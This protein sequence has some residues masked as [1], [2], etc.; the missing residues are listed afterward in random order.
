[1]KHFNYY[2]AA[3]LIAGTAALA[4]CTS[5]EITE[6]EQPA[7]HVYTMAISASLGE[8]S[9][10]TRALTESGTSLTASWEKETDNVYVKK[11][12][13]WLGGSLQPDAD[14]ATATLKGTLSG[15]ALAAN[16]ALTLQFPKS[17]DITYAGQKGTLEDI[18]AN[19]DYATATVTVKEISSANNIV[20]ESETTTFT[21]L[22]PIVKFTLQNGGGTALNATALKINDGTSDV[23]TL[24][25][26]PDATYSTNGSGVLYVAIPAISNKDVTLTAT[27]GGKDYSTTKA[28]VTFANGKY[29]TVTATL[30]ATP[31]VTAPTANSLTYTGSAQALITAGSTSGGTLQY[32][33][34]ED[35]SYSTAIPTAV[36][37]GTYTVYYK[38]V[39]T[40]DYESVAEQSINVTIAQAAG[41][42]N[43]STTEISKTTDD[44]AFTNELTKTGDGSITYT[45]DDESVA[46]VDE[47]GAVTIKG[48]GTTK[49]NATVTD[50]TNYTYATTTAAYTLTVSKAGVTSDRNGYGE[51][52]TQTW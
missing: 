23:V 41:S 8:G 9:A 20:P 13:T 1:M 34:G 48:V 52:G 25:S 31:T 49:I 42:I 29:Y 12:D 24:T 33:L 46:T 50:G 27:V 35:G 14:G 39:G 18:A 28:N 21:N 43:Y 7:K 22:Q 51:G 2:A 40:D 32:K 15:T 4:A 45:S 26:I 5:E 38:V 16:D 30:K 36:N 11:G 10:V 6:V 19:Y 47:S 17:G 3:M 37:A 44:G